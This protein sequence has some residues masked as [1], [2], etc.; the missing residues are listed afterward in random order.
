MTPAPSR[1]VRG[2]TTGQPL[3]AAL[4]L[5]GRRWSLRV[6][7]ELRGGALGFRSLQQRCD[8]MSSSVLHQ[9]LRELQ[10]A[11]LVRRDIDGYALTALGKDAYR[12]LRP[13]IGWSTRWAE[14]LDAA[15][16]GNPEAGAR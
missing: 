14:E 8:D 5:F 10:D 4:D 3:M 12:A 6:L 11:H 16:D 15:A 1:A 2:S 9:R 7:W 13:L